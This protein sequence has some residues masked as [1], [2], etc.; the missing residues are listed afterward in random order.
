MN[1]FLVQGFAERILSFDGACAALC[2][3]IRAK[4]EARGKPITVEDAM[5]AAMARAYVAALA[6]RNVGNFE[7]C[8]V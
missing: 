2:G 1:A 5:I 7:G 4:C 8:G 6:R 3:E